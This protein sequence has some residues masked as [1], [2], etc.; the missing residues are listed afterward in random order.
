E[1]TQEHQ[2]WRMDIAQWD[3]E[4]NQMKA[5]HEAHP[6]T[7]ADTAK[8]N[9]HEA[10]LAKQEDD[11]VQF[12]QAVDNLDTKIQDPK[13]HAEAEL[14]AEH[15]KLK[16]QYEILKNTHNSIK[17]EHDAMASADST[18]AMG[19]SQSSSGGTGTQAGSGTKASKKSGY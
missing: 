6:A 11:E 4:D 5:W 2:A 10:R 8:V 9:A 15:L 13:N 17:N 16:A 18:G 1:M 19:M 12:K 14:L 7:A 3:N